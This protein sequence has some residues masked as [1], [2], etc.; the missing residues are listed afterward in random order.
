MLRMDSISRPISANS[1]SETGRTP[2]SL[3]SISTRFSQVDCMRSISKGSIFTVT[4]RTVFGDIEIF[5]AQSGEVAYRDGVRPDGVRRQAEI[6]DLAG[7]VPL[8]R[9]V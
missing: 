6:A 7:A 2:L 1:R 8:R 3:R 4:F 9:R 5:D